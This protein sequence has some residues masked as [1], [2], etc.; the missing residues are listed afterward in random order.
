MAR[1]TLTRLH[2]GTKEI[3]KSNGNEAYNESTNESSNKISTP[4]PP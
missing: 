3:G 4:P 1:T 2:Q